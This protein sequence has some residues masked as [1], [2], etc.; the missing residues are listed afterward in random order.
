[1][2]DVFRLE[3]RD[4]CDTLRFPMPTSTVALSGFSSFLHGRRLI[5]GA[6]QLKHRTCMK[7]G[8]LFTSWIL[9]TISL[10]KLPIVFPLSIYPETI[11][12]RS[13]LFVQHR[14]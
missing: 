3:D 4:G 13:L 8:S 5:V 2:V 9:S 11:I 1:M 10:A 7:G 6:T 14:A 12:F